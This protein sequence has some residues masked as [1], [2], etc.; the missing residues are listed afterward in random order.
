MEELLNI[1]CGVLGINAETVNSQIF[2]VTE[3]EIRE[4]NTRTRGKD[5]PTDVL[6]F[7]MLNIAAGVIPTHNAYPLDINPDT[8]KL[9]LGDIVICRK[10]AKLPIDLLC[11]HGFLHLLG[12]DH[13]TEAD[14]AVMTELTNRIL[15]KAKREV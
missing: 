2:F 15:D 7:P 14:W 5:K 6:S 4:L 1:A 11:V 9:E 3:S 13:E 10:I 12:Y 8:N